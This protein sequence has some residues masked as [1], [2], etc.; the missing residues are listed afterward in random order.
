MG[1]L[2]PI[3]YFNLN[4]VF[5]PSLN[6]LTNTGEI[7]WSNIRTRKKKPKLKLVGAFLHFLASANGKST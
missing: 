1:P 2:Y 5:S 3:S 6:H 4:S 7:R